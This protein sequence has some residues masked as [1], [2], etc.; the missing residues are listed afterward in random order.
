MQTQEEILKQMTPI[1]RLDQ[2]FQ[3]S[4]IIMEL[5]RKGQQFRQQQHTKRPMRT[6]KSR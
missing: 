6:H 1:Q 3:L 5:Y 4:D 2:A